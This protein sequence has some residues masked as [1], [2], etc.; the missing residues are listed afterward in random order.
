MIDEIVRHRKTIFTTK[1]DQHDL[2]WID[3]EAE[4]FD[5]AL[6]DSGGSAL[7]ISVDTVTLNRKNEGRIVSVDNDVAN[8]ALENISEY[9]IDV[10]DEHG[11][12]DSGTL[13]RPQIHHD[14]GSA[15][16]VDLNRLP[17]TREVRFDSANHGSTASARSI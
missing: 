4:G 3:P 11:G 5:H 17:A 14:P 9:G 13:R 8:I 1:Q 2:C 6:P 10:Y 12:A 16:S 15:E 7:E